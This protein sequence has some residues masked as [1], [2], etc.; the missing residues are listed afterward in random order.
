MTIEI[1]KNNE[2]PF[3]LSYEDHIKNYWK[4]TCKIPKDKNPAIDNNGQKDEIANQNSNAS[5]FYLNSSNKGNTLVE[6][7]CKVPAKKGIFIPVIG[8]EVSEHEVPN[9]SVNDLKRI[10]KNDQDTASGLYVKLDGNE[11]NNIKSFRTPTDE[12]Q[13]EFPK[14]GIFNCPDGTCKAVADGI[15]II[16]QPLLPGTHTIEVK[17]SVNSNEPIVDPNFSVNIK[18]TLDAQ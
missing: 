13:L 11:V 12:F 6:R 14:N 1:F 15:Y 16:T 7:K 4:F 17:G 2:S 3:G 5:V 8:V 18:Y 9:S 10:A